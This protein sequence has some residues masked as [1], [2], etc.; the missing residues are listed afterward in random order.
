[1]SCTAGFPLVTYQGIFLLFSPFVTIAFIRFISSLHIVNTLSVCLRAHWGQTKFLLL[2]CVHYLKHQSYF[3]SVSTQ[4]HIIPSS[5]FLFSKQ[6]SALY[7]ISTKGFHSFL[8]IHILFGFT[9]Q[10][11]IFFFMPVLST[12][13]FS[14]R[15]CIIQQNSTVQ[16]FSMTLGGLITTQMYAA[17]P[18]TSELPVWRWDD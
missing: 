15:I 12:V 8:I 9:V 1:M 17:N 18:C 2:I 16:C 13:L 7:V 4:L 6:I 14:T 10:I 3:N 5:T 11:I